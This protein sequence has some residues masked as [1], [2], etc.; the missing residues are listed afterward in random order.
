MYKARWLQ[1]VASLSLPFLASLGC[2]ASVLDTGDGV[3][4]M[5]EALGTASDT[6]LPSATRPRLTGISPH[7]ASNRG[8]AP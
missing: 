3:S 7:T 1:S 5:T 6:L 4:A 8:G 2:G